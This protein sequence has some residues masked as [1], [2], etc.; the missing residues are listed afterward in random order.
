MTSTRSLRRISW[1]RYPRRSRSHLRTITPLATTL[2]LPAFETELRTQFPISSRQVGY[3][4]RQ[5]A[6]VMVAQGP[7]VATPLSGPNAPP[8]C[9]LDSV[10]QFAHVQGSLTAGTAAQVTAQQSNDG[11]YGKRPASTTAARNG[12]CFVDAWLH[13]VTSWPGGMKT[14]HNLLTNGDGILIEKVSMISFA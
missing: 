1:A 6:A 3:R 4:T 2:Q 14:H 8:Q 12:P 13:K 5:P 10:A 11:V 9:C 7:A